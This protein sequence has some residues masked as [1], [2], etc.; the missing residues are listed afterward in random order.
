MPLPAPSRRPSFAGG[1]APASVLLSTLPRCSFFPELRAQ[2]NY[3]GFRPPPTR[4]PPPRFRDA[5]PLSL[6]APPHNPKLCALLACSPPKLMSFLYGSFPAA[7]RRPWLQVPLH[8]SVL[9]GRESDP[10][11]FEFVVIFASLFRALCFSPALLQLHLSQHYLDHMARG[12]GKV[13]GI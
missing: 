12:G 10:S 13:R 7:I 2:T 3:V 9:L 6:V 5:H 8:L 11:L 1:Y 4:R